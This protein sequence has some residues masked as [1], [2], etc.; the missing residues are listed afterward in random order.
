MTID[1][2]LHAWDLGTAIGFDA[3]LPSD[4]VEFAYRQARDWGD[5][6][7]SGYFDAP[8]SVPDDAPTL[9]KLVALTG[10]DPNW[11]P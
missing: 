4:L 7:E 3:P 10:R 8:V 5:V 11:T 6:S 1:L 2:I 9:D